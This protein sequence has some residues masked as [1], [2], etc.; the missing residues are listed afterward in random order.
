MSLLVE[1]DPTERRPG[2]TGTDLVAAAREAL[3]P[4]ADS[5]L[6]VAPADPGP[7]SWAGAP[8]ALLVDGVY[9]LA[10]RLRRPVGKGRG[11]AN[12]IARSADGVHFETVATVTKD[13]FGAESLERPAIA[14]TP[15]GTWR[16]YVSVATPGTKHWRVDVVEAATPEGLAAAPH[17][18]VLPGSDRLAVKDPVIVAHDG[19]WHL[20]ASCHP[21]DD[22]HATDR[23]TTDY[24]TSPDGLDWTWQGTALRGTPG[25]W[26]QRGVRA[27]CVL[28][29]RPDPV[30]FYDGRATAAENWE[31][32][33]GLAAVDRLDDLRP[34]TDEPVGASTYGAH[35]L[36]YVSAVTLPGGGTRL[37]YE[38]TRADGA[39]ELRTTVTTLL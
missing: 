22:P 3:A 20:W 13:T 24:A 6:V 2:A 33:T 5:E 26:D 10:Y 17:R 18:T 15:E 32:R 8:S 31:E 1:T 25:T 19:G 23:M 9:Y 29:D 12:V 11:F 38:V 34:L 7:G 27:A 37:Y 35:G 28:L 30:A 4:A 39:H 14:V 21:L 36:R 16:V